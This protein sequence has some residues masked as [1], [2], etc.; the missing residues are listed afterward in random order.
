[1]RVKCLGCSRQ[2]RCG[3]S[4]HQ[5]CWGLSKRDSA[6]YK[7]LVRVS[8]DDIS[9]SPGLR[10][11]SRKHPKNLRCTVPPLMGHPPTGLGCLLC[12][13]CRA[14]ALFSLLHTSFRWLRSVSYLQWIWPYRSRPVSVWPMWPVLWIWRLAIGRQLVPKIPALPDALM[15]LS[16]CSLGFLLMFMERGVVPVNFIVASHGPAC[17]TTHDLLISC[18]FVCWWGTSL[19]RPSSSQG[20]LCSNPVG[21]WC[22]PP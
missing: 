14:A 8:H 15:S 17:T 12:S 18:I 1:M 3:S 19:H 11:G 13:R 20:A 10:V 22:G 16:N 4:P 7:I 6:I 2:P 5:R 9:F 21:L